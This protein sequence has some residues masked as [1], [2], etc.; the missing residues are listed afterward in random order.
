MSKCKRNNRTK[1]SHDSRN[2]EIIKLLRN[3]KHLRQDLQSTS[4]L[5]EQSADVKQYVQLRKQYKKLID[6]YGLNLSPNYY[7]IE[8]IKHFK[9]ERDELKGKY[10]TLRDEYDALIEQ[11]SLLKQENDE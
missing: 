5:N 11:Y 7:I 6:D 1:N 8:H 10:Q 3:N 4:K 9:S 2:Y